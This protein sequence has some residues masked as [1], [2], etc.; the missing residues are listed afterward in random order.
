[1]L[2]SVT[3][4]YMRTSP[5]HLPR[6]DLVLS[7]ADS[8]LLSVTVVESDRPS[9][10]ALILATDANGPAMQLV[11]WEEALY[12]GHGWCCDYQ[13]PGPVHGMV[14]A[15]VIGRPGSAAGSWDFELPTGT[16]ANMPLRV[17]WSILLLWNN[18]T[19]SSVLAQGVINVL[20]PFVTGV[21]LTAIPPDPNIPPVQPGAPSLLDLVTS[22]TLRPIL[23]SDT[24]K[25]LETS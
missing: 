19:A 24:L 13:R 1:M 3:L 21:P 23:A 22:E 7:A 15:S 16:F 4:P 18:G 25:Q 8:L 14:L 5:V 17:G 2:Q 10:Q 9:A 12:P 11:L 20:R 6:R